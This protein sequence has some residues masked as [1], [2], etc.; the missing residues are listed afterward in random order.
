MERAAGPYMVGG[1]QLS[2]APAFRMVGGMNQESPSAYVARIHRELSP[3]AYQA[4][5]RD[6]GAVTAGKGT[7]EQIKRVTQALIDSPAGKRYP[8]TESGVRRLMWDHGI[9]LDCSGYVHHAFL[10]ARGASGVQAARF[11]LGD[12][13]TSGLQAPSS[14]VFRRVE[15]AAVRAGDVM[16]LTNGADG[17]GHKVIVY[18]RHEVPPGTEMHARIARG[19]GDTPKSRFHLIE[20]DSSWGAGGNP[21]H[22][23]VQRHAWAYDE[24]SG[25]WATLVKDGRGQ[26][27]AFASDKAG[28]YDHDLKGVYRPRAEH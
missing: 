17:T 13:L 24:G 20:V 23:G 4:V 2:V 19:L 15:P 3:G 1:K 21:E 12:P 18:A 22:G 26:W 27:Q 7:P 5:A 25:R 11:G 8:A 9:G 16:V 10:A 14:R 6:L 28:P